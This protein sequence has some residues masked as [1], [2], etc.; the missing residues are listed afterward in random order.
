MANRSWK[1]SLRKKRA[2]WNAHLKAW[3]E[4]ELTQAEY[5][6][7]HNLSIKSFGYWKRK[8]KKE[9]TGV[10]FYPVPVKSVKA[11]HTQKQAFALRLVVGDRFTIE[12]GDEFAS[13]TLERLMHTLERL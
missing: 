2:F 4:T 9:S 8:Q 1:S 7:Q 11:L 3:T 6:R 10:A 13:E 12:V 5:C